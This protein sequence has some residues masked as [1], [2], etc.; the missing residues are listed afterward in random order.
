MN[1]IAGLVNRD[2]GR[3]FVELWQV[4]RLEF[5]LIYS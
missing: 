2:V 1:Y 3:E 5:L 4:S